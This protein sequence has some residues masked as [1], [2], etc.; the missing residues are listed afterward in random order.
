M[1]DLNFT[2]QDITNAIGQV[3]LNRAATINRGMEADPD[4]AATAVKLEDMTGVPAQGI[5][6]DYDNFAENEKRQA[7]RGLILNNPALVGY[8]QSHPM[9][10]SVSNDD[11]ANLDKFSR[12]AFSLQ[13]L[14]NTIAPGIAGL[15]QE[16]GR[17][18]GAMGQEFQGLNPPEEFA[19]GEEQ[20]G[21]LG[22]S[23]AAALNQIIGLPQVAL[24]GVTQLASDAPGFLLLN[25]LM[26]GKEETPE[27]A[28][29]GLKEFAGIGLM[30]AGI[31]QG[32][33]DVASAVA[34]RKPTPLQEAFTAGKQWFENGEEPPVG[35]H[36][37][38]DQS[39]AQINA[40]A[41]EALEKDLANALTSTTRERS[42]EMFRQLTE[43]L[44]GD[45][46]ISI[47]SDAALALYGDKPPAMGDGILGFVPHIEDQ[48]KAAR[49]TGTDIEIPLKDWFAYVDPQ[50]A[51]GLRQDIR[52]WP[53]GITAR[54]A[55]IPVEPK[56]VVDSPLA[57][58]R[59]ESGLEPMFSIG[60]RKLSLLKGEILAGPEAEEIFGGKLETYS[61]LDEKGK[62]VGNLELAPGAD[63][64]IFVNMINGNAGLWANSFGPALMRDLKK[65]IKA[66]YPNYD[67]I[68]GVRVSGARE[69]AG[70]TG[71]MQMPKVRLDTPK[72]WD[73]VEEYN[74]LK[75]ILGEGYKKYLGSV[76]IK[77][78]D[79]VPW[80][81]EKVDIANAITQEVSRL[82]GG[83]AGVMP[84]AG[85]YH[86]KIGSFPRGL[87][88]PFQDQAPIILLNFLR[89][90]PLGTGRHESVHVLRQWNLITD[91]EWNTLAKASADEGWIDRYD[92]NSRYHFANNELKTEESIAEAFKEW[93]KQADNIRPKTGVGAIF[94]K[95]WEFFEKIR[96]GLANVFGH[97]P[98]WQEIFDKMSSGEVGAREAGTP[99]I[100]G[101]YDLREKMS[102]D[103]SNLKA[104][105]VGLPI[106][107]WRKM[108]ANIQKRHLED[109]AANL[110][111][112]QA[113]ET[114]R[115]TKEWNENKREMSKEVGND[116]RQRPDIAADLFLGSGELFGKKVQQRFTLRADD[117]SPEQKAMLPDHY[118][119]ANGLPAD[120]VANTF[121]FHTREELINSLGA[122]EAQ[123]RLP[124]GGRMQP[125]IFMRNLEKAETDRRMEMKYGYLEKNIMEDARERATSE[126]DTNVLYDQLMAAGMKAGVKVFDKEVIR[127]G[128]KMLVDSQTVDGVKSKAFFQQ[129]GKASREAEKAIVAGD[130]TGATQWLQKQTTLQMAAAEAIKFEQYLKQFN[131]VAK[132]YAKPWD[133]STSKSVEGNFSIFNRYILNRV[134]L[135]NGMTPEWM[136]SAIQDS[137]FKDLADFLDKTEKAYAIAGVEL[138]VPDFL[139]SNAKLEKL[140]DMQSDQ[141]R[142][143]MD[144]VRA[145]DRF[146]REINQVIRKGEKQD[147]DAWIKQAGQQLAD[148]FEAK[149]LPATPTLAGKAGH[150]LN[151]AI[152]ASTNNETLMSRFDGRDP[153]GIFTETITYPGAR[154]ANYEALLHRETAQAMR[155]LENIKDPKKVLDAPFI[156]PLTGKKLTNF[157][158]KNLAAVISNMGNEYNWAVLAKGWGVK[159]DVLWK[160]VEANTTRE[161]IDRAQAMSKIF[162]GLKAK[163]DLVYQNMYGAAPQSVEP[164]PFDMHGKSYDGWYHPVIGDS[165][166]SS[167]VNKLDLEP[168]ANFWPST[169]NKYIKRRTGA[170]QVVDL[171]YDKIP[172]RLGQEIH[173]IAFREFVTNTAKI[174]KDK[175][176]RQNITKFYGTEYMEEMD[177]WLKRVA[178][179]DGYQSGAL[180]L[181]N[182]LSDNIRQ[183]VISTQIAFNLGTVEKHGLTAWMYSSRELSPN[184]F[185]SV[186]SFIATTGEVAANSAY[187]AAM[188]LFGR[189]AGLGDS[190]WKF[191]KDN[192]EEIQRRERNY[193]DTMV[194]A[195]RQLEGETNARAWISQMGAK[196]VAFSDLVSA[197]PLWLARYRE[198]MESNGGIHGDA[199]DAANLS[200]RRA[201]GSTAITNLPRIVTGQN[202]LTPW[203][204][205]LYGFMGTSMQ[206]RIEIFHDINDAYKL[207]MKG[208]ITGAASHIPKI[209]ASTAVYVVM[210]GAIEEWITGQ[211]TD[212]R[213]GIGE[214]AMMFAFSTAAQSIIA[215]RDLVHDIE[216]GEDS[217]GLISTPVH[218]VIN[219]KRDF[220]HLDK[221]HAGKMVQ[222]GCTALGDLAG[223][224]PKHV[225]TA[226]RYGIDVFDGYQHPRGGMDIYRG[227]V[228]GQQKLRV[229]K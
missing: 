132:K 44:Y 183:N 168:I 110:K 39:K 10:A 58:T 210:T 213:R 178:G 113:E 73:T 100:E 145:L 47:N 209:L 102:V 221:A 114:R 78:V 193:L 191:V 147:R 3:D 149:G 63:K 186:P 159:P 83:K 140:G 4:K 139:L 173:D 90:D 228:S 66:L 37:L 169:S 50:V 217:G 185:K 99:R 136:A 67:Y 141:G 144:A 189:G 112:V 94:Q 54:E 74:Q 131:K 126:S 15:V 122:L 190:L 84:V 75:E 115:Q 166:R 109:V 41:V 52:V 46:S 105:S 2:D 14:A 93:T 24:A 218:D 13:N 142:A 38:I 119:S 25:Q 103:T 135:K 220:K 177:E 138:P 123:K 225:G 22:A 56:Q 69:A 156:D 88:Q 120:A 208:D 222:D 153:H 198:E 53:G 68:T 165:T 19:K 224:C 223:L 92:I 106:D 214:K 150:I 229:V 48:L 215:I 152:A 70:F 61:I 101:A 116:L 31:E 16:T 33:V 181:A 197:I 184:L 11:W 195:R 211:F 104:E 43:K 85:I 180:A 154:A 161:D 128:A 162:K 45:T 49:D 216:T 206:R 17:V 227:E 21:R 32:P 124:D 175:T 9:A 192:S 95:L 60:D 18:W 111:H 137:G 91:D 127:T 87:M 59:A 212:D 182:K 143:V 151:T 6:N 64:T 79:Q 205:S 82:V 160:W 157:T 12:E 146:G 27:K 81:Q 187:H 86:E 7:A 202:P 71:D 219:F 97:E 35:T 36:P 148:K 72:G 80:T 226:L 179:V 196:T 174:F 40:Q 158:R 42:P 34:M 96:T 23:T 118:Y 29:A 207:G 200:V 130:W 199:V 171:T 20:Y 8:I 107:T 203:M 188:D 65:Q 125:M 176:F 155:E 1:P 77:N 57:A 121:G 134:G 89:D 194:G 201:H 28:Q 108:E 163:S 5:M 98:T 133:P 51:T 55:A 167:Y 172:V 76:Y 129:M 26:T 62:P 30:G 204:T 164:R 117:L 170:T